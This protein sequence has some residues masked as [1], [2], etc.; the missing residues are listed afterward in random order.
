MTAATAAKLARARAALKHTAPPQRVAGRG[1]VSVDGL[2]GPHAKDN[3][4]AAA[5][6]L[7]AHM[8][9]ARADVDESGD[10]RVLV[11]VDLHD[12][13]TADILVRRVAGVLSRAGY[14]AVA[15][16]LAGA[17]LA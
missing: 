11:D 4:A 3:G 5:V 15:A 13:A 1:S 8:A 7:L 10:P 17:V 12:P 6:P 2:G 14:H 16:E 9:F